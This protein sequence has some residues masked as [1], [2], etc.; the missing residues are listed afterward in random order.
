MV[1]HKLYADRFYHIVITAG[2]YFK[3]TQFNE[4]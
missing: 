3:L 1:I 4:K 2:P